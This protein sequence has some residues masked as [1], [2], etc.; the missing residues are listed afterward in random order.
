MGEQSEN[1][2]KEID[3]KGKYQLEGT[4]LENTI[5]E[6]EKRSRR[7]NSKAGKTEGRASM[8]NWKTGQW[9]SFYQNNRKKEKSERMKIAKRT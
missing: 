3:N 9:N 2:S 1:F 6:L 4:E 5:F 8:R 7:L